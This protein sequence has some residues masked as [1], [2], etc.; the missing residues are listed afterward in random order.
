[1]CL[2]AA[3]ER[4]LIALRQGQDADQRIKPVGAME[5]GHRGAPGARTCSERRA[6]LC[7]MELQQHN[8]L[9]AHADS[10]SHN[11]DYGTLTSSRGGPGAQDGA[12]RLPQL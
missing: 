3:L 12:F 8:L 10:D 9:I 1:M 11:I 4:E 6:S 2:S 7:I 5:S